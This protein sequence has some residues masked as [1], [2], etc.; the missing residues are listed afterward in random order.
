MGRVLWFTSDRFPV[1]SDFETN[2]G[3]YGKPLAVWLEQ[4]LATRGVETDGVLAEDFGWL[5]MLKADYRLWIACAN[6]A[7]SH[8]RW[9]VYVVAE[10]GLLKRLLGRIDPSGKVAE[11]E[12]HIESILESTEGV[13]EMEWE[14]LRF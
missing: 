11:V 4:Q 14:R 10:T 5:V 3:I 8:D 13:S 1:G 12:A 9:G 7:D 2:P 6:E